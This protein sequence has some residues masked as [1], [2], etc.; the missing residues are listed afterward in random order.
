M[1]R[2]RRRERVREKECERASGME[3]ACARDRRTFNVISTLNVI[4]HRTQYTD[5][6]THMYAFGGIG[7]SC[8]NLVLFWRTFLVWCFKR[9]SVWN[10]VRTLPFGFVMVQIR[11]QKIRR[12][13]NSIKS[14]KN[15]CKAQVISSWRHLLDNNRRFV[16]F[17]PNKQPSTWIQLASL[18]VHSKNVQTNA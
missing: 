3:K 13:K 11:Q 15:C 10:P 1:E 2:E 18:L 4:L 6:Q 17:Y 12:E 5:K 14:T 7:D 8:F 16:K 9:R